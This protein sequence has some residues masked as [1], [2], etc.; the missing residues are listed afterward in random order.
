MID[1]LFG[2]LNELATRLAQS[3]GA[4]FRDMFKDLESTIHQYLKLEKFLVKIIFKLE[5]HLW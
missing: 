3:L 1:E 2:G 5:G 4:K